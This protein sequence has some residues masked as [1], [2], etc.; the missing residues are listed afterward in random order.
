MVIFCRRSAIAILLLLLCSVATAQRTIK[1]FN[2]NWKF[3]LGDDSA[4]KEITYDDSKWRTLTLPHDWSIEGSFSDKY[5]T[6]VNEGALLAGVGWYRK[7]FT[8][9]RIYRERKVFIEFEGVYRNSELWINGHYLG[10]RPNGYISFSYDLSDFLNFD[11]LQNVIAVRVDNSA[12]PNSRWYTGSGIYRNV[13]LVT[14]K[15]IAIDPASVQIRT[16]LISN[17]RAVIY[18]SGRIVNETGKTKHVSV[19]L[20]TSPP[21]ENRG[22][23]A[24]RIHLTVSTVADFADSIIVP[25]PKV[26]S[27]SQPNLYQTDIL[28]LPEDEI[29]LYHMSGFVDNL[30]YDMG[31]REFHF[32][33]TKGFFLN[34]SPLKI[35]GVCIHHDLGA[36]GAA[37]NT[38]AIRRQLQ[39]LKDMGCNAIRTAHNPPAPELLDLC[40]KMGFLV[41]DE[42]FD[43]W[44]K[45]KNKFDYSVDFNQWHKQ[46]LE[47]Q[48][49]RDRNHPCVFM[50]S[51]GNEIREQFDST[52]TPIARELVD[53]VKS[54]DTTR[55]VT[56]ALTENN[57]SKNFIYQSHFLDVLGFNYK[58]QDYPDLPKRKKKKKIIASETASALAT[59]GR[60]DM[61]SD[62]IRIWPPDSKPFK[63]GNP[64]YTVSAY[65][66]VYAY[67]GATHEQSW[68]A[69]KK[70]PFIAGEFVWSGFDFLGEPVPYQWPARSSY[71]GI[72]D[73]A[74]FPKDV[75]YMYQSEWTNKPV[76][77]IFPHWNWQPGQL[78]DIWAYYNNADEVELYLNGK[79]QGIRKRSD[80]SLHVMWRVAFTPGTLKAVSRKN[81]K[82][83]LTR[84]IKTAGEPAKIELI[85]DMKSIKAVGNDL[86]FITVRILDAKGNLVPNADNLVNFSIKGDGFIAGV[87]NGNPVSMESF[88]SPQRKAFS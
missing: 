61:P 48:I 56:S 9:S 21:H 5:P 76:L 74:G 62:S 31:I 11:E 1:D 71:Y 82:I 2:D 20:F 68:L 35:K 88:K 22:F 6:T 33:S 72:I 46:D 3:L 8:L 86:S 18:F 54:L 87:D 70:Y 73:L 23:S 69:V 84:E 19:N 78:V 51:I 43:M 29:D 81:G 15:R 77:H 28:V 26:W 25:N 85:A 40:D 44:K 59:R 37:V 38:T 7:T 65:D 47:D 4:A 60:Y 64:D 30:Q 24:D 13:R 58:L 17:D 16:Q 80:T 63:N 36:L 50:W 14:T 41:M 75:Y 10:K 52:G 66:N 34:G 83:V 42:A 57:P 39:L 32:D 45:R 53:I 55:P 27:P 67:W 79:S 49:K 12:Q